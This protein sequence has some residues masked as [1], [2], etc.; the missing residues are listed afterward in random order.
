MRSLIDE[1]SLVN[2]AS[3][4]GVAAA[5]GDED[6]ESDGVDGRGDVEDGDPAA[7]RHLQD[8]ARQVHAHEPFHVETH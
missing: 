2:V 6:G 3:H 4:D 5:E 7:A 8:V 1:W